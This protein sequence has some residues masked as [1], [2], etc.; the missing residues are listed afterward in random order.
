MSVST[1]FFYVSPFDLSIV[2]VNVTGRDLA[3]VEES[4]K[5]SMNHDGTVSYP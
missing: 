5:E 4:A 2:S 1:T 3:S